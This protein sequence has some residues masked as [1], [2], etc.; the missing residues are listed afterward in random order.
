MS[1]ARKLWIIVATDHLTWYTET[2]P[3]P[4]GRATD[5]SKYFREFTMLPHGGN[6]RQ[7]D[8]FHN[9]ADARGDATGLHVVQENNGV[10]LSNEWADGT[11][12]QHHCRHATDMLRHR[13]P[14]MEH[15]TTL[16]DVRLQHG[17]TRPSSTPL[18][19]SFTVGKLR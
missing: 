9:M 14:D 19:A 17:S 13:T 18:F 16:R 3:L 5:V 8:S 10:P 1:S 7:R 11:S 6:H 4:Y 2:N 12:E 15:Y